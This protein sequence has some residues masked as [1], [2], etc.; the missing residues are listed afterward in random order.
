MLC[1]PWMWMPPPWPSSGAESFSLRKKKES[2]R[3]NTASRMPETSSIS[4]RMPVVTQKKGT[5]WRKPKNS[6]GSPSGVSEPPMLATR[7]MKKTIT[8]TLFFRQ[9]LARSSGRI[10]T[11]AAPVVPIHEA[12]AVPISS[13]RKFTFGDPR[14]EPPT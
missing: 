11:M 13:S 6:G 14:S 8:C 10:I 1:R 2:I 5:P 7:K 12:S 9:A 4:V 3:K